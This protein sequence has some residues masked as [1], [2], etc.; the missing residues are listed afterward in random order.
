MMVLLGPLVAKLSCFKYSAGL[1][2]QTAGL[3]SIG[4]EIQLLAETCEYDTPWTANN[5]FESR[6]DGG[7]E[8]S[9]AFA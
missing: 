6:N 4:G 9:T 8:P 5:V 7:A 1:G 2:T 3:V